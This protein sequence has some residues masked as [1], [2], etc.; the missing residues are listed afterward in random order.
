[1]N[2]KDAYPG[3][4]LAGMR[5]R[6]ADATIVRLAGGELPLRDAT[7]CSTVSVYISR[8]LEQGTIDVA[9]AGTDIASIGRWRE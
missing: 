3:N 9:Y 8:D 1:L 7:V 5:A 2:G 4:N 6:L